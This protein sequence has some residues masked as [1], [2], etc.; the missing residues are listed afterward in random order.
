MNTDRELVRSIL[1]EQLGTLVDPKYSPN[2]VKAEAELKKAVEVVFKT[3]KHLMEH[4]PEYAEPYVKKW[5]AEKK[6]KEQANA[7]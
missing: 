2:P 7:A 4:L 6:A 1:K 5:T 3:G